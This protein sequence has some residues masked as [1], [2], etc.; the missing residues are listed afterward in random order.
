MKMLKHRINACEHWL[1]YLLS[2]P[3]FHLDSLSLDSLPKK[4][5]VYRIAEK[6][7]KWRTLYVGKANYLRTRIRQNLMGNRRVSPIKRKLIESGKFRSE[8]RVKQYLENDCFVQYLLV[9]DK[10]FRDILEHF[11]IA[12]LNPEFND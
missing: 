4:D 2:S 8:K 1:K 5:A 7:A 11:I 9:L 6:D 10:R 3:R 12:I